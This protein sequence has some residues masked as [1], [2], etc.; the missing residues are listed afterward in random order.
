M[1]ARARILET[2]PAHHWWGGRLGHFCRGISVPVG[3]QAPDLLRLRG[4]A[5]CAVFAEA[6]D[7]VPRYSCGQQ[8]LAV[9]RAPPAVAARAPGARPLEQRVSRRVRR[10]GHH[11]RLLDGLLGAPQSLRR[12]R[13]HAEEALQTSG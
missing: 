9:S 4:L 13:A 3:G 2:R 10:G 12:Q 7:G 11:R 5:R 1:H 6:R 8:L